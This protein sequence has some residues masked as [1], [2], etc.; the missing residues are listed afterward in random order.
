VPSCATRVGDAAGSSVTT[1]EGVAGG[2]AEAVKSSWQKLDV[3]QCGYCRSGQIMSAI[4][5][6]STNRKP[7]DADINAAMDGNLC[8]CGTYVRVRQAIHEAARSLG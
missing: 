2:V 1:I 5:L 6:L 8:R 7:S 4:S 3:V